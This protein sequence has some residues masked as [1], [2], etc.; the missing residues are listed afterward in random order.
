[1][2]N[3]KSHIVNLVSLSHSVNMDKD[4]SLLD[5]TISYGCIIKI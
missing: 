3:L 1:M 2:L 5:K 4:N